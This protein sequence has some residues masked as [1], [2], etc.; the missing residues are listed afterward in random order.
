MLTFSFGLAAAG[1]TSMWSGPK[2][3]GP[4][5]PF[6]LDMMGTPKK[7]DGTLDP[8]TIFHD[9]L[10]EIDWQGHKAMQRKVATT[11]PGETEFTRWAVLVFDEKTLLP[12]MTEFRVADGRFLRHEFDG[13]HVT[14]TR[15]AGDFRK[16]LAPGEKPET[17]TAK[18]DLPEPAFAWAEGAGT[19][20]LF[21]VPLHEGF[22]GSVPVITGAPT[23]VGA[24]FIGPCYVG[25]MSYKVVG[26]EEI[27]GLSGQ[28]VMTWKV[29]VP[30]TDFYFW[31]KCDDPTLE[32]VTWP[33]GT[34]TMTAGQSDARF[35]MGPIVKK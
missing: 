33:R 23:G 2:P 7:N 12:Y 17:G 8:P 32:G 25:R 6:V 27:M 20:V 14:E 1:Q 35:T 21:G 34:G 4:L 15:T 28:K 24:C 30:E 3:H 13:L 9:V 31:I 18:F 19:L 5:K 10:E 16:P 22:E 11:K 29:Y 26:K